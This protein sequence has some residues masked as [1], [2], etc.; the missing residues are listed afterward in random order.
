LCKP[1]GY[2]WK[3]N[4]ELVRDSLMETEGKRKQQETD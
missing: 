1:D 4:L 2:I 3:P